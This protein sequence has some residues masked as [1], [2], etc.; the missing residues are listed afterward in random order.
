[1]LNPFKKIVDDKAS[2]DKKLLQKR[3]SGKAWDITLLTVKG[4]CKS[5]DVDELEKLYKEYFA[6]FP[7]VKD[8][9]K[10]KQQIAK[11]RQFAIKG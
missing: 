9:V 10:S 11:L 8:E 5:K 7:N 1:M 4:K 6:K 2:K 3:I